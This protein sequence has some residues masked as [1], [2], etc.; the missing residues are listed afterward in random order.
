M[1]P[2]PMLFTLVALL[3]LSDRSVAGA[4]GSPAPE[5]A[6]ALF[7]EGDW[8]GSITEYK[9]HLFLRPSAPGR[10]RHLGRIADA[11]RHRGEWDGA[12]AYFD[13]AR[14]AA[15]GD[16]IKMERR[17]DRALTYELRGAEATAEVEYARVYAFGRNA[18]VRKRA[19]VLFSL[20]QV[21]GR[22]WDEARESLGVVKEWSDD[23]RESR[24]DSLFRAGRTVRRPSPGTARALST[25]LPGLGQA[26]AGSMTG[27]LHALLLNGLFATL[28]GKAVV[29]GHY[30]EAAFVHLPLLHRYYTGNR[31]SAAKTA[32]AEYGK[33]TDPIVEGIRREIRSE[34]V[35][36]R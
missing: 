9:R 5:L 29:D 26:Y 6:D 24:L 21:R 4:D 14:N 15:P 20:S 34:F 30:A 25:V 28:F 16:S 1:K 35:P 11:Y 32:A 12:L 10:D 22:R 17:L 8:D 19:G 27:A 23:R 13:K 3:A 33:S 31:E 2:I 7:E 18:S 36:R